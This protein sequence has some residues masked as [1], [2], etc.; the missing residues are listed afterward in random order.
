MKFGVVPILR[1][2]DVSKSGYYAWRERLSRDYVE[3]PQAI[4]DREVRVVFDAHLG[5]YG[6][7]RVME[8]LKGKGIHYNRKTVAKSLRRQGLRARAARKFIAT[9]NS[10]HGLKVAPN[11]L[12][13]DF[14]ATAPNQKYVQ[15]ITY[16]PTDEGWLYLAVAYGAFTR[17]TWSGGD[18]GQGICGPQ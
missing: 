8:E 11:L 17:P 15:D 3:S 6:A 13:Q 1:A 12:E 2:L 10:N 16:L 7:I 5:R 18:H 14:T 9:T 4:I